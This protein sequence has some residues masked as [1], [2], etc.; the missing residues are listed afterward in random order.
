M[1]SLHMSLVIYSMY[2]SRATN[3]FT[4]C[5][6]QNCLLSIGALAAFRIDKY[7]LC[8]K[9][10]CLRIAREMLM[11]GFKAVVKKADFTLS[12]EVD[13]VEWVKLEDALDKLREGGIA[14][15]L[16]KTVMEGIL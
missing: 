5:N 13:S 7:A 8:P 15:Q 1:A 16:V 9:F 10:D 2:M 6:C 4:A 12:G 14:W 3:G 11:L